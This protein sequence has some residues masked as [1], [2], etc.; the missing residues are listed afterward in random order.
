MIE[1]STLLE[2]FHLLEQMCKEVAEFVK[3]E[4]VSSS[5]GKTLPEDLRVQGSGELYE[6]PI[7]QIAAYLFKEASLWDQLVEVGK[8]RILMLP[9]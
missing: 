6:L 4:T 9:C 1:E 5:N 7:Q 8:T 2:I 3:E